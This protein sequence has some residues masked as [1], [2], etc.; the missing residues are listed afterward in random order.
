MSKSEF[1]VIG[2]G[3]MGSSISLNIADKGFMLSVFNRNTEGEEDI[4][5]N[6]LA[7]NSDYNNIQG[8]TDLEL[9]IES[10]E[11]PRKLLIMIKSGAAVD[12]V[13]QKLIPLLDEEDIIIDGGNSH[14]MNTQKR[15]GY[16]A[17]KGIQ[18]VGCGISG[19]EEGA[20]K[21]PSIMPG[22]SAAS[23]EK[24]API[25]EKI[26]AKDKQGG[27]CC[28][29]IGNDAAG[30]FIKM[31]H[32]GI[33]YVEMQLLAEIYALLAI[34]YS[35]EEISNLFY[36]WNSGAEASYLL[37]ITAKI[38]SVKEDN[39]F[40]IDRILDKAGNKGTGSWSTIAALELGLP[41]TMMAASVFDRYVSSFKEKREALSKKVEASK[42]EFN[43]NIEQLKTAY[44]FA[45]I[46]NH[47]QGFSLMQ[48]AS[49]KYDWNLNFSE[50]ARI[51]T[52]GCII[53]SRLMEDSIALF[54]NYKDYLDDAS[55][56]YVL[57][58]SETALVEVLQSGLS[59]RVVLNTFTSAYGYWVSITTK[60]LPANI[61][62]AQRDFFGAHTYQR[63]DADTSEFFHTN[64]QKL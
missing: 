20:R 51:W 1:G 33:E 49:D 23:Y 4:V 59:M 57:K 21:G 16:L 36:E 6:F 34:R 56:F 43:L 37:E 5:S 50:I 47:H 13:I 40:L 62:Q 35:N 29:F 38:L 24:I 58:T 44:Q 63:V 11:R 52:N 64:W 19:G 9:F 32:N 48:E 7:K 25:L 15:A 53:R 10:L 3:V 26:A 8:F 41:N 28:T 14:Y 18:F 45:R 17:T 60:K 46:V 2:L 12:I 39:G 30:H 54:K 42:V 31:V 61:I 27:A 55:T 22:G